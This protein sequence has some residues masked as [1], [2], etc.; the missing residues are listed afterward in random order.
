MKRSAANQLFNVRVYGI[1]IEHGAILVSDE[2]HEGKQFTKFPGGGLQFGEGTQDCLKREFMEE[3]NLEIDVNEHF[4]TVDFFQASAFDSGQQVISI[5]YL[6]TKLSEEVIPVSTKQFD[7]HPVEFPTQR[8][9]WILLK[10]L[11]PANFTFPIDKH[12]VIQLQNIKFQK[13]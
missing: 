7:F 11:T 2:S 10:N 13:D 3:L 8:F 5:Y 6:V 12:V 4:Y 9:R 1:L